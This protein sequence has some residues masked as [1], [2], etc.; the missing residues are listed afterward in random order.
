ME[1]T[2][3]QYLTWLQNGSMNNNVVKI[4]KIDNH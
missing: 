3:N 4:L 1:W 2:E